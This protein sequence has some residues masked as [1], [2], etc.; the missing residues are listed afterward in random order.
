MKGQR[1]FLHD[2]LQ[3]K[4]P[5]VSSRFNFAESAGALG[6]SKVGSIR[7]KPTGGGELEQLESLIFVSW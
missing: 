5:I 2:A 3:Q 6:I 4:Q 7:S 1:R